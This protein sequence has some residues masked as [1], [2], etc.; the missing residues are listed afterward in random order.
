[1]KTRACTRA[2]VEATVVRSHYGPDDLVPVIYPNENRVV[3]V[4]K[5]VVDM[6]KAVRKLS[7]EDRAEF[8]KA[9]K[10]AAAA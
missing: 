10:A 3:M 8:D 4:P 1:M 7:P 9:L 6:L 5:Q 2:E